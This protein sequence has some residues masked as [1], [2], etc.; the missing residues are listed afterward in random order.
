MNLND[1]SQEEF[2]SI[3]AYLNGQLSDEDVMVF[4]NRLKN[5]EGFASKVE[6]IKTILTGLETQVMK[7]QL[8]EFHDEM[9]N[10]Q[11]DI[12]TN[13]PK[14]KSLHWKR[15]AVAAVLIIG[16]GSFWLFNGNSNDR[17]YSNYFTPDPGLPTTM[18]STAN[19]EF[20]EAMVD[21][22]QGDYNT[23]GQKWKVLL[24]AKPKSD[25]LNYFIGSALMADDKTNEAINHLKTV[26]ESNDGAFKNEAYYYLGLAYLKS[27][28]TDAAISAL[29]KTNLPKAKDL[30]KKL[31]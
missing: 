9:P 23:A 10:S 20:Y 17:L 14:V 24:E 30:L 29:K 8:D 6:D 28:N 15:I 31:D 1:I 16:L 21:Y 11:E 26:T 5:E 25:T 22:K 4:E 12:I 7:E 2:E 27:G 13:E 3:E 19:Y 18:S